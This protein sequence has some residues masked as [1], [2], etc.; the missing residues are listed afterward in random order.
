MELK[1][2]KIGKKSLIPYRIRRYFDGK[3]V[4]SKVLSARNRFRITKLLNANFTLVANN[5]VSGVLYEDLD[6]PYSTPFAGLYILPADFVKLCQDFQYY[7]SQNL[8]P[9]IGSQEDFPVG[10]LDDVK[11]YFMHYTTF[12]IAK[13]KWERR[14]S[15]INYLNIGFILV[16]RD[17]CTLNDMVN[18]DNLSMPNKVILSAQQNSE[19]KSA[20]YVKYFGEENELGNVLE[21]KNSFSGQRIMYEFD[22]IDWINQFTK[23]N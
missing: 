14:K 4:N 21:F 7:M 1:P 11:I 2:A 10:Q 12:E 18:F 9:C 16:Q 23:Y 22:F 20:H 17:G 13:E 6:L 19:C 8:L 5:C 15:R 3:Y